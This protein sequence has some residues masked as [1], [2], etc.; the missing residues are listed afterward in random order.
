M[1]GTYYSRN[2]KISLYLLAATGFFLLN[3]MFL[4]VLLF[5]QALLWQ[6][7]QNPLA[8]VFILESFLLMF[9]L[10][11]FLKKWNLSGISPKRFIVLS[12][13]FSIACALPYALLKRNA[14]NTDSN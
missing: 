11:Y 5:D 13:L 3:G 7:L 2:E 4:Y 6:T 1:N 9:V 12:L 14:H 10:A 8:L